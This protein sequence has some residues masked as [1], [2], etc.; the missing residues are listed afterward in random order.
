MLDKRA[1][2][3]RLLVDE[4]QPVQ[5]EHDVAARLALAPF[6]GEMPLARLG[7][8]WRFSSDTGTN[9]NL[10]SAPPASTIPVQ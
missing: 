7:P 2:R 5:R 10:P 3:G 8:R 1:G 6:V 4:R 9:M